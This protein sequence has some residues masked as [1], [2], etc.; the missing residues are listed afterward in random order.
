M[1]GIWVYLYWDQDKIGLYNIMWTF[2]HCNSIFTCA[3]TYTSV[4][5]RF[6]SQFRYSQSSVWWNY[7]CLWTSVFSS[8]YFLR[9]LTYSTIFR[10]SYPHYV[11]SLLIIPSNIFPFVWGNIFFSYS[12]KSL[13][14]VQVNYLPR[15][16][17]TTWEYSF[18]Y[19]SYF[20]LWSTLRTARLPTLQ[21]LY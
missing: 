1:Y 4:L 12:R 21:S 2:S 17:L 16:S 10:R 18:P 6:Q 20:T 11:Q 14:K 19:V 3:C 7:Q 15:R 13:Y 9:S 5:D 8:P